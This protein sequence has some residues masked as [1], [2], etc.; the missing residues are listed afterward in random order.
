MRVHRFSRGSVAL[1]CVFATATA[2]PLG[3]AAQQTAQPK[4]FE[5]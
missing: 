1:C 5:D 2:L 3:I 4:S